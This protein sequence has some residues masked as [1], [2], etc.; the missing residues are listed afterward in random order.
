MK[1]KVN[2]SQVREQERPVLCPHTGNKGMFDTRPEWLTEWLIH[3][4]VFFLHT[5]RKAIVAVGSHSFMTN[6]ELVWAAFWFFFC[7]YNRCSFHPSGTFWTHGQI[8]STHLITATIC[9][10]RSW[11]ARLPARNSLV[12]GIKHRTQCVPTST[13]TPAFASSGS[14]LITAKF[15]TT[16]P[17]IFNEWQC[18]R[19]GFYGG[20]GVFNRV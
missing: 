10:S 15:S 2:C 18:S 5:E 1:Q 14:P 7:F 6:Y 11:S 12:R 20:W 19:R 8:P 17:A 3:C 4:A 13:P 9:F 16:N